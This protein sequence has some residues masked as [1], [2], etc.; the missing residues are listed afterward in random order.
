MLDSSLIQDCVVRTLSLQFKADPTTQRK[1]VL[2]VPEAV[3]ITSTAKENLL[4]TEH[5]S[6]QVLA[7]L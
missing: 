4:S 3:V 2:P 1:R 7:D 6:L 5:N